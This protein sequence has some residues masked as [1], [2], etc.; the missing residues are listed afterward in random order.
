MIGILYHVPFTECRQLT[1]SIVIVLP[2]SALYV[3]YALS[4][5]FNMRQF[6]MLPPCHFDS[7]T[8]NGEPAITSAVITKSSGYVSITEIIKLKVT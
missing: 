2:C 7:A 5:I 1:V 4:L 8:A 6:S 3:Y